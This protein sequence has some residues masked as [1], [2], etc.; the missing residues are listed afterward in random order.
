MLKKVIKKLSS[1]LVI[2]V[3]LGV[4]AVFASLFMAQSGI[5]HYLNA[6]TTE[7]IFITSPYDGKTIFSDSFEFEMRS[8]DGSLPAMATYQFILQEMDS[9]DEWVIGPEYPF[10]GI[11]TGGSVIK[12]IDLSN[13]KNVRYRVIGRMTY[14]N[15]V[16]ETPQI[17][18]DLGGGIS[19]TLVVTAPTA[20]QIIPSS[21][22]GLH[23]TINEYFGFPVAPYFILETASGEFVDTIG[24]IRS[25]ENITQTIDL[26]NYDNGDYRVKGKV[27]YSGQT[28]Y[29]PLVYFTLTSGISPSPDPVNISIISPDV[30]E[31]SS[32]GIVNFVAQVDKPSGDV[33]SFKFII[34]DGTTD[35][36]TSPSL[37]AFI[38]NT[39]SSQWS[40]SQDLSNLGGDYFAIAQA[41]ISGKIYES[42]PFSFTVT[43][44]SDI[45]PLPTITPVSS[46]LTPTAGTTISGQTTF[47]ANTNLNASDIAS[48]VFVLRDMVT[49]SLVNL[50]G[51]SSVDSSGNQVWTTSFNSSTYANG[52]YAIKTSFDYEG[53]VYT[54]GEV[55]FS[56]NNPVIINKPIVSLTGPTSG[57]VVNSGNSF[58][59]SGRVNKSSSEIDYF[60]FDIYKNGMPYKTLVGSFEQSSTNESFWNKIIDTTGYGGDYQLRAK[61]G[62]NNE[63]YTSNFIDIT[64]NPPS[65]DPTDD[66]DLII[67]SSN[68]SATVKD[69]ILT[70]KVNST[71]GGGLEG[72]FRF[73]ILNRDL[74]R[75]ID[76]PIA[77]LTR[78]LSSTNYEWVRN[79]DVSNDKYITGNYTARVEFGYNNTIYIS[80]SVSFYIDKKTD[81]TIPDDE[82]KPEPVPD[83]T[84]PDDEV[85][86]EPIPDNTVPDDEVKPEP[87]PEPVPTDDYTQPTEYE[88]YI[89]PTPVPDPTTIVDITGEIDLVT[90]NLS[91]EKMVS[92]LVGANSTDNFIRVSF[93]LVG[94]G[95][96]YN[97]IGN[98]DDL[99]GNKW[100]VHIPIIE[101]GI[102]PGDYEI[103]AKGTLINK[104]VVESSR[105]PIT[106]IK[107]EELNPG[108]TIA[109]E[110]LDRGYNNIDDC[111]SYLSLSPLCREQGMGI[112]DLEK[113]KRFLFV[114]SLPSV[115]YDMG[116]LSERDCIDRLINDLGFPMKCI[117]E[118]VFDKDS[119]NIYIN[120]GR[121]VIDDDTGQKIIEDTTGDGTFD[122]IDENC[123]FY[124]VRNVEECS[125]FLKVKSMSYECF[126]NKIFKADECREYLEDKY[127]TLECRDAGITNKDECREYM[128]KKYSPEIKCEGL[129]SWH[130]KNVIKEDYMENIVAKEKIAEKIKN[131]DL[132]KL[133][134]INK[135]DKLKEQLGLGD[136][137]KII[138]LID[139][140]TSIKIAIAKEETLLTK[141]KDLIQVYP[142]FIMVDSDE[143]GLSDDLEKEIGTD[144]FN[145]DTDNDGYNDGEE[146]KNGYNP[147][148]SAYNTE[149]DEVKS[150]DTILKKISPIGRAVLANKTIEHPKTSGSKTDDLMVDGIENIINEDETVEGYSVKGKGIAGEFVTLYIYSDMPVVVTT[151]VDEYGNW[152][153]EFKKSLTD[154][155]HEIYVVVNDDTGRVVSKSNPLRFFINEARAESVDEVIRGFYQEGERK[156]EE[157]K[158]MSYYFFFVGGLAIFGI[159]AFIV[160]I[161]QKR[162][163]NIE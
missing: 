1:F 69:N 44:V 123:M 97:F 129:D 131:Q 121:V 117:E 72:I 82:V 112:E 31:F 66:T 141:E 8:F 6:Q 135:I 156:T 71:A 161:A 9:T 116:I 22:F 146:I 79:I 35:I 18:F 20:N 46:I 68:L 134:G 62:F 98:K 113:C 70:I 7:S 138:P 136:G 103:F 89:D 57:L 115:C 101:K 104:K 32:D 64:V 160:F 38:N 15:Q 145:K 140:G 43:A 105:Y 95:N 107:K 151:K 81:N 27:I 67:N 61:V 110:C 87:I 83:N 132:D 23:M 65:N 157:S 56:I 76:T 152:N 92:F 158:M 148:I 19:A 124:G 11:Q 149:V 33:T 58:T 143:D 93:V 144:P 155:E 102:G 114:E 147:I 119:C 59:V 49:G 137:Q 150:L 12:T 159:L 2:L 118:G 85:K 126:S 94:N 3:P 77:Y 25:G 21:P 139:G 54:S 45:D 16:I 40:Y 73:S 55:A 125:E 53:A 90:S 26:S 39:D 17:L 78:T 163:E 109:S 28:Y 42:S 88:P 36:V 75:L 106:I 128:F 24:A 37:S 111:R 84:V 91:G 100:S 108:I 29:S 74:G 47:S 5:S 120:D 154:G 13:F 10:K 52:A 127:I 96:V 41:E 48:L 80:D 14:N 133:A 63:V 51:V 162:R 34:S 122:K 99:V 30:T 4:I 50:D 130:C 86:P 60:K 153:Y 142:V